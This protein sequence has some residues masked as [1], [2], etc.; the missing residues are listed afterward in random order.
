MDNLEGAQSFA[1]TRNQEVLAKIQRVFEERKRRFD[2][3]LDNY[4]KITTLSGQRESFAR[5]SVANSDAV[6]EKIMAIKKK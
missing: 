1:D 6:R 2:A 5:S 4:K 3:R